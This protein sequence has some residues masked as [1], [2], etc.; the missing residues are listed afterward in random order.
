[1]AEANQYT[2]THK[3]LVELIIKQAGVH[4]GKWYL[5]AS[6]GFAPGN[7]GP[8]PDQLCPGTV[9]AIQQ[10]GI[11]RAEEATPPEIQVDAAVVNPKK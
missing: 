1:M 5:M 10:L 6:L 8:T 11:S 2:V 7:Y 3:E 4:E 9:V